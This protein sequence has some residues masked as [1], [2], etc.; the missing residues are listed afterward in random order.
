M[1]KE[2]LIMAVWGVSLMGQAQSLETC[3]QAARQNYPLIKQYDL[4]AKT[5]DLTIRNIQKGWLPQVQVSA[6]GTTQNAVTAW[7]E[8]IKTVYRSMGIEMKGLGKTQYRVGVDVQQTLYDGGMMREQSRM[9][10]QQG[11]VEAAQNEVNLY[12][13]R[14]RVNELYFGWLLLHE[15]MRLNRDVQ[16]L[17]Q[18]SE[19]QLAAMVK[20]GIAAVSDL[21]NVKAERLNAV[22]TGEQLQ[23][24]AHLMQQLLSTFCGIVVSHPEK[25]VMEK[26]AEG[27]NHRP[28]MQLFAA[29][30]QL[31]ET[32]EKALRAGLMPRIG[33]FAQG[34]YGYPGLN[35]FEDMMGRKG[36]WNA[37]AGVKF[38][39][40]VGAL[41][42]HKNDQNKLKLQR[43]QTE[44]LRNAFLFNN[45]LEQLQQQEAIQRYEKLMKSDD[46]IIALRTRVRKAAESKL[47]HGLIDSNRLVQEINQE[48]AAKTQQSIHEINLLKA[49][50]DLKYTVNG[51]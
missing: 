21:E 36:S 20:N 19:N 2:L 48:N 47:A 50:S 49:Q 6:Q 18:S 45:R 17:L 5:T 38:T 31:A 25:P 15:Q 41:Y 8:R 24:Q 27:Q 32:Q 33:L 3:Q 34:Y 35:L 51:L 11:A 7:P 12:A 30:I 10:R 37:L 4:I 23:S 40:N 16:D 22:Q 13:V 46:E 28:E 39:W 44:N 42:T 26:T 29:Q 43:A 14:Q 1:K 9:V